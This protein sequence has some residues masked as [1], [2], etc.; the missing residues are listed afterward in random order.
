M[1]TI[2]EAI[3]YAAGDLHEGCNVNIQIENGGWAVELVMDYGEV[4]EK[5]FPINEQNI[6]E[7]IVEATEQAKA[8][9]SYDCRDC[10]S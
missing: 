6:I 8:L 10:C 5:V 2:D 4:E 3:N 7:S 9:D 1:E